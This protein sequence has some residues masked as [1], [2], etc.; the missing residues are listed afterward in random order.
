MND[1]IK[2]PP[3]HS[4]F[5]ELSTSD[6]V[7]SSGPSGEI[8]IVSDP[9]SVEPDNLQEQ[10]DNHEYKMDTLPEDV[11]QEEREEV[12]AVDDHDRDDD[13][14]RNQSDRDEEWE[15]IPD[16]ATNAESNKLVLDEPC[17]Q[18]NG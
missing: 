9:A 17:L 4:E 10:P 6:I 13:P 18:P 16:S 11:L 7:V 15:V 12:E 14:E 8:L 5:V 3:R 1:E 2:P